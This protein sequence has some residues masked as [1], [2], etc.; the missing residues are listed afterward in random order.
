MD[1]ITRGGQ[2]LQG[3]PQYHK[4]LDV[5]GTYRVMNQE[6]GQRHRMSIGTISSDTQMAIKYRNG[7]RIGSTEESFIARLNPGDTFQFAGKSLELLQ[8]KELTAFVKPLLHA[9]AVR[10]CRYPLN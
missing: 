3:Y 7:K 9:G 6:I 4:V 5:Q 2:A 10:K 1:F 8:V